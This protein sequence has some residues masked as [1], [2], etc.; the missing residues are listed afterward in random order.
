MLTKT[1]PNSMR[2]MPEVLN[3]IIEGLQD[4][5]PSEFWK[6]AVTH[7][8]AQAFALFDATDELIGYYA[9]YD[10]ADSVDLGSL[11]ALPFRKGVTKAALADAATRFP[12]KTFTLDAFDGDLTAI[13]SHYGFRET[14]RVAWDDQD[15]PEVWQPSFGRPDVVFMVKEA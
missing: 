7:D 11:I 4:R 8:G 6:V 12:G 13:Y 15:A 3:G 5:N 10:K 2:V 1:Y 9:V 14:D